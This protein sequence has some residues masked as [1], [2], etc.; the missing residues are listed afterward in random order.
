MNE[1]LI[2]DCIE[3]VSSRTSPILF[4]DLLDTLRHDLPGRRWKGLNEHTLRQDLEDFGFF[5]RSRTHGAGV[6]TYISTKDFSEVIDRW[7]KKVQVF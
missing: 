5:F 1:K 4:S 2:Q 3:V 7:G 6:A